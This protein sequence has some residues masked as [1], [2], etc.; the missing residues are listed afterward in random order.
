MSCTSY[1]NE[2]SSLDAEIKRLTVHL[3]ALREQRKRVTEHLYSHM[4]KNNID[5]VYNGKK[6]VTIQSVAPKNRKKMRPKNE[7]KNDA[8]TLFRET[9]IPNPH[10][11]F[12]K[13]ESLKHLDS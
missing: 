8:I 13:L 11:F 9:G 6:K 1:M 10:A 4:G 5:H 12:E 3:K 7:R 2:L